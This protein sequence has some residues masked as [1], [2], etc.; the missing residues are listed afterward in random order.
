MVE[1]E[2]RVVVEP[3]G[4]MQDK[5]VVRKKVLVHEMVLDESVQ[6]RVAQIVD[7]HH[8]RR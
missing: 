6:E 7:G 1:D 2:P 3:E 8:H 5:L 4:L